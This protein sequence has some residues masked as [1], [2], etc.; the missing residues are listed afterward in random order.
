MVG[1]VFGC[2]GLQSLS[3]NLVRQAEGQFLDSGRIMKPLPPPF[4]FAVFFGLLSQT[5]LFAEDP[6]L[7]TGPSI[8]AGDLASVLDVRHWSFGIAVPV[9]TQS[10]TIGVRQKVRS[11]AEEEFEIKNILNTT[12]KI[13]RGQEILP[14]KILST[15]AKTTLIGVDWTASGEG[16]QVSSPN[17]SV[18]P[19]QA[20]GEGVYRLLVSPF[21]SS[22][23]ADEANLKSEIELIITI[24]KSSEP[25]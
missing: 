8:A 10:I 2:P 22:N 12:V 11:G 18:S 6:A 16:M 5:I 4:L 23:G 19:P 3:P 21:D 7:S 15:D 9:G 24:N 17:F 1:V 25:F 14:L 13:E 20:K